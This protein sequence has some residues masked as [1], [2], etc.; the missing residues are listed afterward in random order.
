VTIYTASSKFDMLSTD[1]RWLGFGYLGERLNAADRPELIAQA[2]E[3]VIEQASSRGWS[4]EDLFT[5]ANSKNGRWFGDY[6][7]GG[8]PEWRSLSAKLFVI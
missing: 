7:F 8:D 4:D 2:D 6:V 5:W 1:D 3:F